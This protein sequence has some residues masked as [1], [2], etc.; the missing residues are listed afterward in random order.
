MGKQIGFYIELD[1]F[2]L[3]V[4]KAFKLGFKVLQGR[5]EKMEKLINQVC[6]D[7]ED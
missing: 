3:L 7:P 4:K 1:S 2:N 5:V 6:I